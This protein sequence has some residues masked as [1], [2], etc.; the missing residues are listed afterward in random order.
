MSLPKI[1]STLTE[2]GWKKTAGNQHAALEKEHKVGTTL[3]DMAEL[4]SDRDYKALAELAAAVKASEGAEIVKLYKA[5]NEAAASIDKQLR[6]AKEVQRDFKA[7]GADLKK[8]KD[9]KSIGEWL[10]ESGND[11]V[12][13]ST[14]LDTYATELLEKAEKVPLE[15]IVDLE[16]DLNDWDLTH[17]LQKVL[18]IDLQ[19]I[20]LPDSKPV[21]VSV[22][23]KCGADAAKNAALRAEFF[24]AAY[25]AGKALGP[26]L[27]KALEGIDE[28][29]RSGALK[30]TEVERA[31]EAAFAAFESDYRKKADEAIQKIWDELAKDRKEYRTY[32]I[33]TV[34]S[35]GAKI[36]GIAVGVASLAGAG[37]TGAGT[38]IGIIALVK[39]SIELVGKIS[40]GLKE[41]RTLGTEINDDLETLRKA[42]DKDSAAFTG[43]KE[44]GK[45]VLTR[46]TGIRTKTVGAVGNSLKLYASKLQGCNVNATDLGAQIDK[47]LR[48][49]DALAAK[50]GRA[51]TALRGVKGVDIGKL[52]KKYDQ[53]MVQVSKIVVIAADYKE[54]YKTGQ[55]ALVTW[56]GQLKDLEADVPSVAKLLVKW[57][58]PV[59]DFAYVT[60]AEGAIAATGSLVRELM[61]AA[62]ETEKE[63]NEANAVGSVAGD[64]AILIT[65]MVGK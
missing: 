25:A 65:G 1:P 62:T 60:S 34:V 16:W 15:K 8:V 12:E 11:A 61:I 47:V 19:S 53:L 3:A 59:L 33:K 56:Q 58:V 41:A 27:K 20:A 48:E 44:V 50:I 38:V 24:E 49:A 14:A 28:R 21:K 17:L 23:G 9:T 7:L 42:F 29:F 6:R 31:M 22:S 54:D 13:Y 2:A 45:E 4:V 30:P 55:K 37:W 35:I 18:S 63:L 26:A 46:L 52:R 40:D 51:E 10:I 43:A 57:A 5:V 36:G 39:S 64:V 32:K